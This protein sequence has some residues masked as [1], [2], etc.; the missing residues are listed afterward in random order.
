[1]KI[2]IHHRPGG[3]S[4]RWIEYCQINSINYK[5]VD[6][7]DSDIV[8][9]VSDCDAFMWHHSQTDYRDILFANQLIYSLETMGIRCFPNF[10]TTWH[11]DD[12]VG[13]KYLFE[14]V[15]ASFVPSYVFYT[16][17]EAL[18]WI[19]KTTFPKVFKLRGGASAANVKL[20]HNA[21]EARNLVRK[22]FG[23]GF[24]DGTE[25]VKE[26]FRKYKEGKVP[27]SYVV[28]G[29]GRLFIKSD[30]AKLS[31]PEKGYIYFQDFVPNNDYDIRVCIVN[32]K[33]FALKRLVRKGDFRASGSGN[34]IYDIMQ[35]DQRCV[36]M[37]FAINDKLKMQSAALDFVF[38]EN[39][40]PLLVE[41]SYGFAVNAYDDCEGYWDKDMSWHPGTHFNFCGWMVDS[42]LE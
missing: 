10:P 29:V 6:A 36:K 37:S 20:V 8:E 15:K 35:I 18:D 41:I 23:R 30:F 25:S 3:F 4:D 19:S 14:A 39:K 9:Q 32:N 2:A 24:A 33:A 1:M 21:T 16:K 28:K 17:K 7:Y 34:I 40:N 22:A 31:S 38:D 11:F 12:K 42:I 13:Q 26:R 5:V 27:I